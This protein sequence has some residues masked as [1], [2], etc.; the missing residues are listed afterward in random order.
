MMPSSRH[1]IF[2]TLLTLTLLFASGCATSLSNLAPAHTLAPGEVQITGVAQADL[3][4]GVFDGTIDAGRA[5]VDAAQRDDGPISEEELRTLLDA[6][7][8]WQLFL[9]GVTP[10][11][12]LRVGVSDRPL[13]GLDVGLRYNGNVVK[14]DVRLQ[15]W[16][17]ASGNLALTAHAAYG[18]HRSVATSAVEWAVMTEFKRHDFEAGLSAGWEYQDIFKLYLSP[19]YLYSD[20]SATPNL[21]DWLKERIPEEYQDYNP[22]RFF[23][24]SEMHYVGLNWGAMLGYRWVFV[25][26]DMTMMRVLFRPTVLE[27][28][29]NYDNWVFAPSAGLSVRF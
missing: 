3:Y 27:S 22:S 6:V 2:V 28:S 25:H 9:P 11:L 15:L 14:P 23:E 17:S 8:L 20:L 21:P 19:R 13:A 18:Y 1:P 10:E 4:T 12:A 7:L 5:V 16:E 26:L 24:D 29:R